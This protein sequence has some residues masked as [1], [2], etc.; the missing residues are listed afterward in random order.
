MSMRASAAGSYAIIALLRSLRGVM[1][2]ASSPIAKKVLLP[3]VFP[4]LKRSTSITLDTLSSVCGFS[5]GSTPQALCIR[6][7]GLIMYLIKFSR[8]AIC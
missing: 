8:F 1:V 3:R 7:M 5:V 6:M 4:M 2:V